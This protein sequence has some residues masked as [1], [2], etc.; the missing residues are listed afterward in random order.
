[1]NIPLHHNGD[2]SNCKLANCR[3]LK[4]QMDKYKE[5]RPLSA[6]EKEE[7][8]NEY[9]AT[10]RQLQFEMRLNDEGIRKIQDEILK[11]IGKKS[12][13]KVTKGLTTNA[14]EQMWGMTTKYSEGKRRNQNYSQS[15]EASLNLVILKMVGNTSYLTKL[16][17]RM[18]LSQSNTQKN[19]MA[20]LA[21]FQ[22]KKKAAKKKESYKG[23]SGRRKL[24]KKCHGKV[25]SKSHKYKREKMAPSQA[26]PKKTTA[27]KAGPRKCGNCG[28]T[29]GHTK[30]FCNWPPKR[31]Q[32]VV[33]NS[34]FGDGDLF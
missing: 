15:W 4:L 21:T 13:P 18:G 32:R 30:R 11:R 2:H 8:Y 25:E 23:I 19:N 26:R 22:D 1:L 12:I 27:K 9:C 5:I 31:K 16:H 14:N 3:L 10:S 28:A 6:E 24:L 34:L 7:L 33:T 17:N 20:R 29:D